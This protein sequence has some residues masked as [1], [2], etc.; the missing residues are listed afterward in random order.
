MNIAKVERD[1]H[2]INLWI[3][4]S[5]TLLGLL[6]SQVLLKSNMVTPL[7]VSSIFFLVTGILYGKAWKYFATN[8]PKVLGRFYL[9]GSMLRMFLTVIV[10]LIGSLSYRGDKEN[11]LTYVVVFVVYYI[12]AMFF[13]CLYFFRI[14]KNNKINNKTI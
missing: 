3:V 12:I 13:D 1:Y 11:I 7:I 14:E 2:K 10:I 8:S 5:L 4:S 9:A 6:I